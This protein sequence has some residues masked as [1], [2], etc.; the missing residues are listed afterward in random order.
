MCCKTIRSFYTIKTRMHQSRIVVYNNVNGAWNFRDYSPCII[1]GLLMKNIYKSKTNKHLRFLSKL[2]VWP[3]C[4]TT[5]YS[6]CS[7]GLLKPNW[8][9][10][11][12]RVVQ[13]YQFP[14]N[15]NDVVNNYRYTRALKSEYWR[16]IALLLFLSVIDHSR[17]LC[18]QHWFLPLIPVVRRVL[19]SLW[20]QIRH[21]SFYYI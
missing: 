19:I 1:F 8:F 18:C 21:T 15:I 20:S 12:R 13:A 17:A 5:P 9:A 2:M 3:S 7:T 11:W 14:I 16:I 10:S 6:P 4:Y